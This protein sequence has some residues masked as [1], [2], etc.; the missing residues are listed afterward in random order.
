VHTRWIETEFVNT[1]PAYDGTSA[2]DAAA[3]ARDSVVVEV[4]GKRIEVTLP[5]GFSAG[6]A[7][8]PARSTAPMKKASKKAGA[9]ASGD[10]VAAPMQGTVVKVAVTEGQ[11]V[12]AG[13][14]V[15]VV[16][17]MKM[18]QPLTAHKAGVITGLQAEV[19]ATLSTGDVICEIK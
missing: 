4:A 9:G 13:E 16:E 11:T 18:E 15:V 2:A 17:A 7:A 6:A 8:A 19:G 5:A 1:I 10:A 3:V 14:L 12:E